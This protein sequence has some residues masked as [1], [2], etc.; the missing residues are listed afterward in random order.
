[1]TANPNHIGGTSEFALGFNAKRDEQQADQE[2]V[3]AVY[4]EHG[5]IAA[6]AVI[7]DIAYT[8]HSAHRQ[9]DGYWDGDEW[10][11]GR[12]TQT[13]TSK[14]GVQAVEGDIVLMRA[15]RNVISPGYDRTFFSVRLGWNCSIVY[16]V[17]SI[18][19][20]TLVASR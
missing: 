16:G 19:A 15:V 18:F 10:T 5:P 8:E 7:R 17:E 20:R 13:I 9:Y 6:M 14:G 1:M 4:A 12:A 11:L 2:R 3:N